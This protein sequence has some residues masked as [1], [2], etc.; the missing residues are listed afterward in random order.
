MKYDPN[1]KPVLKEFHMKIVVLLAE[2]Y[3]HKQIGEKLFRSKRTI[4]EYVFRIKGTF[5]AKNPTH[6]IAILIKKE[7]LI[8]E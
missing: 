1:K 8:L 4:D 6:L 2:G 3:T 5:G 7:L